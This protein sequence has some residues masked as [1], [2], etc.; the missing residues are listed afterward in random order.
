MISNYFKIAWRTLVR[1]K[2]FSFINILG[3]SLGIATSFII[4]QYVQD[5]LSYDQFHENAPNIARMVFRAD[6]NGGKINESIVMAPVAQTMKNDFPEVRDATRLLDYGYRKLSHGNDTFEG[7]RFAFADPNIFSIFTLPM[8][9][10]DPKTALLKPHTVVITQSTAKKYFGDDRAIG[11]TIVLADDENQPYVVT[12]V[13][14][15]IPANSHFHFDLF[16][17]MEGYADAKSDSW[18]YGGFHTYLLLRPDSEPEQLEARFPQ[19]V[20]TYMGPQIQE[21]MGISLEQFT[22]QGNRF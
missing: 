21:H 4:M 17:S 20:K 7:D 19:M 9:E 13:I 10:G 16:G 1:N 12:G 2:L 8:A 3:L 22:T 15:D 6:I 18:M 5:E 14:Q 11:Q